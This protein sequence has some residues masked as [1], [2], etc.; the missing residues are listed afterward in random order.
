MYNIGCLPE[1]EGVSRSAPEI[2]LAPLAPP[3]YFANHL[4]KRN[5]VSCLFL[6]LQ[7]LAV[8]GIL[9]PSAVDVI[10]ESGLRASTC[11]AQHLQLPHRFRYWHGSCCYC[12]L[13][14]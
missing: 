14:K 10:S 5:D 4:A 7:W 8:S 6:L 9:P 12:V 1:I 2:I 11:A 13:F 3:S